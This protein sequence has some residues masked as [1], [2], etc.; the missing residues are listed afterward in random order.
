M[1]DYDERL[2]KRVLDRIEGQVEELRSLQSVMNPDYVAKLR[3]LA[4]ELEELALL[5][6]EAHEDERANSYQEPSLSAGERG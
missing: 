5:V 6:W 2:H 3:H 1:S 4:D